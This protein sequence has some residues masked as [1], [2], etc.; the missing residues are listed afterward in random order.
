MTGLDL[1]ELVVDHPNRTAG[2]LAARAL[3]RDGFDGDGRSLRAPLEELVRREL[4][5]ELYPHEPKAPKK[6]VPSGEGRKVLGRVKRARA[7]GFRPYS[8]IDGIDSLVAG[9]LARTV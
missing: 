5:T 8:E 3:E 7:D 9:T 2:Y 6:Y 4:V 1:L